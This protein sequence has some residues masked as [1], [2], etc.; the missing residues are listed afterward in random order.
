MN[1]KIVLTLNLHGI[2]FDK[3]ANH[4]QKPYNIETMEYSRLMCFLSPCNKKRNNDNK[5]VMNSHVKAVSNITHAVCRSNIIYE[6]YC[7]L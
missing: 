1:K 5:D 3:R 4:T 7:R 2:V 6:F